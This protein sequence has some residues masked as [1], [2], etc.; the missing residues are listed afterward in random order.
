MGM[1]MGMLEALIE[2]AG[3]GARA[4]KSPRVGIYGGCPRPGRPRGPGDPVGTLTI[5]NRRLRLFLPPPSTGMESVQWVVTD[6]QV[7][8]RVSPVEYGQTLFH[9]TPVSSAALSAPSRTTSVEPGA[10]PEGCHPVTCPID[11]VFYHR[12]TP[13]AAPFVAL[14]DVVET[15]RTLGLIEAM[16][17]FNAVSYGGPGLPHRARIVEIRTTDAGEV[18]QGTVLFVVRA[19]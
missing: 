1:E 16:K 15:G 8:D 10:I 6:V 9:L 14:G 2:A 12:P 7:R 18:R 13:G 3:D 17:S 5:L 19:D 4:V 11:G